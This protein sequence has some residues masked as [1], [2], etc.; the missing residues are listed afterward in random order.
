MQRLTSSVRVEKPPGILA[1]AI[2]SGLARTGYS[3]LPRET[4]AKTPRMGNQPRISIKSFINSLLRHR[5]QFWMEFCT[6]WKEIAESGH[7]VSL[8]PG[9]ESQH[10]FFGVFTEAL[11]ANKTFSLFLL[12]EER[13][14]LDFM[15]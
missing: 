1:S 2:W 4:P 12:R 7:L 5:R 10:G 6:L 11:F 9:R 15:D 3:G 13:F 8:S 14:N